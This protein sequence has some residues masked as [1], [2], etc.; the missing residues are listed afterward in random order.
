[1]LINKYNI[2]LKQVYTLHVCFRHWYNEIR[3]NFLQINL[4]NDKFECGRAQRYFVKRD[5][6]KGKGCSDGSNL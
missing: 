1:M 6:P 2:L 4:E 3:I 5:M